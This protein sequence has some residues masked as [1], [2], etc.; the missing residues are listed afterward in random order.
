MGRPSQIGFR[1]VTESG[2]LKAVYISGS[3]RPI[4]TGRITVP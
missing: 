4:S 3:A 2:T 1:A